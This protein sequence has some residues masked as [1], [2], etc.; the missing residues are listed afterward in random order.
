MLCWQHGRLSDVQCPLLWFFVE[1]APLL[2]ATVTALA[3]VGSEA[4]AVT[5]AGMMATALDAVGDC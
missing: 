1:A 4:V 5:A 2:R 3:P